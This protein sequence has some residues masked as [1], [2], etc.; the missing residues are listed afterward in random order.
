MDYERIL[1]VFDEDSEVS[2]FLGT[3]L[4]KEDPVSV[5]QRKLLYDRVI[6]DIVN[7]N[8]PELE[9]E[10]EDKLTSHCNKWRDAGFA[11]GYIFGQMFPDCKDKDVKRVIRYLKKRIKKEVL[12]S[13]RRG[14]VKASEEFYEAVF[15]LNK[16]APNVRIGI[17]SASKKEYIQ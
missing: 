5:S 4:E 8:N 2:E 7:K 10:A 14:M 15:K 13:P 9:V 11:V 6:Y 12:N 16:V 1:E 17:S 3:I